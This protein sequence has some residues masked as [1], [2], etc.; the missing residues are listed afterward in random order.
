MLTEL[1]LQPFPMFYNP[2]SN[3][4][5][6]VLNVHQRRDAMTTEG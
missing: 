6:V 3:N 2:L 4:L 1:D 5:S